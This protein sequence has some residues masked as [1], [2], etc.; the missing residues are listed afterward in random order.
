[1]SLHSTLGLVRRAALVGGSAAV[2]LVG[3][4][5]AAPI[6][7]FAQASTAQ[8]PQTVHRVQGT[9]QSIDTTANTFVLQT[10]NHGSVTVT[11]GPPPST[12]RGHGAGTH[13]RRITSAS[14][15]TVGQQVA[16]QGT[17]NGSTFNA[18]HVR[19]VTVTRTTGR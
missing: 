4:L 2:V 8:A 16:A 6:P 12:P 10:H 15:L 11:F 5:V 9:V 7:T 14:Q 13:A 3:A 18:V 19:A 1:M 17:L